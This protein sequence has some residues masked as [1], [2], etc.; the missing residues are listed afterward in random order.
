MQ[1]REQHPR[2]LDLKAT[3]IPQR[4]TDA[5]LMLQRVCA[6]A[7]RQIYLV[8]P[9]PAGSDVAQG[10]FYDQTLDVY[11]EATLNGSTALLTFRGSD[12]DWSTPNWAKV[13]FKLGFDGNPPRHAGFQL[14]WQSLRAQIVSWLE[15]YQPEELALTGHSLGAALAAI[16]AF[17]LAPDWRICGVV[18]FAPPMVGS[19]DFIERYEH[20]MVCGNEFSLGQIT[21]AYYFE[22]DFIATRAQRVLGRYPLKS[23]LGLNAFGTVSFLSKSHLSAVISDIHEQ[24]EHPMAWATPSLPYCAGLARPAWTAPPNVEKSRGWVVEALAAACQ[25]SKP[26]A[27]IAY[28]QAPSWLT[29]LPVVGVAV[30]DVREQATGDHDMNNYLWALARVEFEQSYAQVRR[31]I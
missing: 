15:M 29:L 2:A 3:Y 12:P 1:V 23:V 19:A 17:D 5:R 18:L 6:L 25:L 10:R 26:F 9:V 11:A 28:H 21:D 7:A 20:A 24:M 27:S 4:P 30:A 31:A 13:N 22:I 16:A 8:Q 14:A